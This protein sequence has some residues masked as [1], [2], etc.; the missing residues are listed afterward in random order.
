MSHHHS[1]KRLP[2]H[3]PRHPIQDQPHSAH[4]DHVHQQQGLVM[5]RKKNKNFRGFLYDLKI[6]CYP[7]AN[8]QF[9]SWL[10]WADHCLTTFMKFH[11]W[12]PF[13]DPNLGERNLTSSQKKQVVHWDVELAP[14]VVYYHCVKFNE[15][16]GCGFQIY[17]YKAVILRL[18][19]RTE[20][21][22]PMIRTTTHPKKGSSH[23]SR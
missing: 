18:D 9:I 12:R 20:K 19:H 16:L 5:D 7:K 1:P 14:K 3:L 15:I 13:P 10:G 23:L 11:F 21:P 2:Y 17:I 8:L 6:P 22:S 4:L